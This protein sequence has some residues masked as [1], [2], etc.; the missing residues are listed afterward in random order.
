MNDKNLD[1][2]RLP[3]WLIDIDGVL[4]AYAYPRRQKDSW[5]WG[6]VENKMV[7]TKSGTFNIWVASGLVEFLNKAHASNRVDMRWCTT[8]ADEANSVFAPAFGL[9]SLPVA[10]YPD[11]TAIL[12][13]HAPA[14]EALKNGRRLIWTDDDAIDARAHIDLLERVRAHPDLEFN[15]DLLI[16][17]PEGT[18]GLTPEDCERIS[19][20]LGL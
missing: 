17:E 1:L 8:W 10:A 9:P 6:W 4:N 11:N 2:K 13:K 5:K 19:A 12:W 16:I 15:R 20:F 14:Y 3:L 7:P 18:L